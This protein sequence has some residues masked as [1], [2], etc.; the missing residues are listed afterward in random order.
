[1]FDIYGY[2]GMLLAPVVTT[3]PRDRANVTEIHKK[4]TNVACDHG[5]SYLSRIEESVQTLSTRL[6]VVG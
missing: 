4:N 5:I 3:G 6:D 1:M 2:D